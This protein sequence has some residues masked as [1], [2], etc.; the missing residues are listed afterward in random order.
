MVD[1]T[2]EAENRLALFNSSQRNGD[3]SIRAFWIRFQEIRPDSKSG[4]VEITD[5][6]K[7]IRG[8]QSLNLNDSQRI[9]ALV[10]TGRSPNP[11]GPI[12]LG[13]LAAK[14]FGH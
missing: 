6:M 13:D 7:F 3:E 5:R 1:S 14:L 10:S 11:H 8:A 12:T 9:S 4:G 2:G